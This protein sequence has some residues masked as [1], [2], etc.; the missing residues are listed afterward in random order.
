MSHATAASGAPAGAPGAR[1]SIRPG[2][3]R[4]A[5]GRLAAVLSALCL[6]ALTPAPAAPAAIPEAK[7]AATPESATTVMQMLPLEDIH[8]G[9]E[10]VAR[11]L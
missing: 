10:G 1:P 9:M 6:L 7:P 4:A 3:A 8:A 2:R 5:T 11:L